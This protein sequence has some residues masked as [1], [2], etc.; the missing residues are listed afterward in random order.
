MIG[1]ELV[2]IIIGFI[3]SLVTLMTKNLE[4]NNKVKKYLAGLYILVCIASGLILILNSKNDEKSSLKLFQGLSEIGNAVELQ[5]DSIQLVLTETVKLN[6]RLDS[7][8]KN[9]KYI[10][11]QR[12][13]SQKVFQEQNKILEESN[14]LTQKRIYSER[15]EVVVYGSEIKFESID[16]AKSVI[17]INFINL[18]KRTASNF[19]NNVVL[20]FKNKDGNYIGLVEIPGPTQINE[21][22]MSPG[23]SVRKLVNINLGFEQIK[24]QTSGGT[25]IVYYKYYDEILDKY[26]SKENRFEFTND[27]SSNTTLSNEDATKEKGLNDLLKNR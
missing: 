25:I 17:A 23:T 1:L 5:S 22:S 20:A 13:K 7:I 18:G 26:E 12:E 21:N 2:I 10:I 19:L 9:T 15:P 27:W 24:N 11:E 16:S 14:I 6:N 3:I 8:N 4:S